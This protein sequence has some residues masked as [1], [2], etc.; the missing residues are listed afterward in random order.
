MRLEH[1]PV[2]FVQRGEGLAFQGATHIMQCLR[3]IAI[4]VKHRG[5]YS[6]AH[7]RAGCLDTFTFQK[8]D[9]AGAID[10]TQDGRH[11]AD[12]SLQ[13]RL[14]LAGALPR[15]DVL[16][17]VGKADYHVRNRLIHP[18]YRHCIYLQPANLATWMYETLEHVM[19]RISC[20]KRAIVGSFFKRQ[21]SAI[22]TRKYTGSACRQAILHLVKVH[23]Q[24]VPGSLVGRDD[25]VYGTPYHY[26]AANSIVGNV[27]VLF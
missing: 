2:Y 19:L 5:D 13:A 16:G 8:G 10:N 12:D 14:V 7:A 27:Q 6:F 3:Y 24:Y 1:T 21:R 22:G 18:S 9:D 4:E 25:L 26:T 11:V 15:L 23:T 17:H 20:T